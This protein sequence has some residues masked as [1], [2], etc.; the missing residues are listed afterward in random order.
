MPN[1]HLQCC[2]TRFG[3]SEP[4]HWDLDDQSGCKGVV[5]QPWL[6]PCH[7]PARVM[8][9][10]AALRRWKLCSRASVHDDRSKFNGRRYRLTTDLAVSLGLNLPPCPSPSLPRV[11]F[12]FV[13]LSL[14]VSVRVSLTLCGGWCSV[15]L[16]IRSAFQS[17][18]EEN[19]ECVGC[20]F[21]RP[22]PK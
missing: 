11:Y 18:S 6:L 1:A 12:I 8:F 3:L 7:R 10:P 9:G 15:P 13:P 16:Q 19:E 2:L 14:C 4:S 22:R 20:I 17:L 5:A 21:R